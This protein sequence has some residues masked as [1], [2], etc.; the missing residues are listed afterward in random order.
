MLVQRRR[1]EEE[2][3]HVFPSSDRNT[4][5]VPA[6]VMRRAGGVFHRYGYKEDAIGRGCSEIY[7][8]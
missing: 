3:A 4:R 6:D 8:D 5:F 1:M 7:A 2:G